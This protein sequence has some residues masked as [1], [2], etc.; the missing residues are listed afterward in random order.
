QR[1]PPAGGGD[2]PAER[3][4]DPGDAGREHRAAAGFAGVVP[5]DAGAGVPRP[6]GAGGRSGTDR[7]GTGDG[8]LRVDGPRAAAAVRA[9]RDAD[10]ARSEEHT[11]ELQS[12]YDLVCRLLLE[13]KKAKKPVN[14]LPL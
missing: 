5:G 2:V 3:D 11:S 7:G 9:G 14:S 10:A 13:K 8:C 12:P 4:V 6:G 1:V